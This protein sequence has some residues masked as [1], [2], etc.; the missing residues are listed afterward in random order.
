LSKLLEHI[1]AWYEQLQRAVQSAIEKS[2]TAQEE[3]DSPEQIYV[4]RRTR[5]FVTFRLPFDYVWSRRHLPHV[6]AIIDYLREIPEM[7]ELVNAVA[8]FVGFLT[9]AVPPDENSAEPETYYVL[10]RS[11]WCRDEISLYSPHPHTI[12]LESVALQLGVV[13]RMINRAQREV[14]KTGA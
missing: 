3:I 14:Q 2:E 8:K 12:N 10:D 11:P 6:I 9:Y 4:T 13:I 5:H 7:G 1:E